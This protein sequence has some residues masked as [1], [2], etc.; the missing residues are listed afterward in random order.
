MRLRNPVRSRFTLVEK[1]PRVEWRG[2]LWWRRLAAR[3]TARRW[4]VELLRT[5]GWLLLD[6]E[7]T[8]TGPAAEVVQVAVLHPSGATLFE[9]CAH[10]QSAVPAAAAAIHGL[11][12]DLLRAALPYN[13][14]HRVLA[15]LLAGRRVVAFN[16][17]FDARVLSQ[18]AA[19]YGLEPPD[20]NWDCAMLA[21]ACYMGEWS[22][23]RGDFKWQ[24]LPAAAHGAAADCRATLDLIRHMAADDR[25]WWRFW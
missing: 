24:R 21:Y 9:A 20:A 11:T 18:T 10:P 19:R 15:L 4:A 14:V 13:A 17:A 5:D 8:G 22:R 23:E 1:Q 25:P 2:P 16:A 7:T 3:R 6:T 12:D